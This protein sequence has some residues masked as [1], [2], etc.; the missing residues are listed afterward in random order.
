MEA[1]LPPALGFR[2]PHALA[3]WPIRRGWHTV[4]VA[5]ELGPGERALITVWQMRRR[6]NGRTQAW[7]AAELARDHLGAPLSPLRGLAEEPTSER[8]A[9]V[10][11]PQGALRVW[12]RTAVLPETAV[13]ES[14]GW[15]RFVPI[16]CGGAQRWLGLREDGVLEL[17]G[18]DAVAPIAR[19]R[20]PRPGAR[21]VAWWGTGGNAVT[22]AAGERW[23][24]AY[25]ASAL[26]LGAACP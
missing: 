23:L 3:A 17:R 24:A 21:L 12:R 14:G 22:V 1:E 25:R 20:L 16:A 5:D 13:A 7:R 8:T 18:E 2:S 15:L 11:A 19:A 10:L 6:P 4:L 9:A 26:G